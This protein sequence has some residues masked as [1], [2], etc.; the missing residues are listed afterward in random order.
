MRKGRMRQ[1]TLADCLRRDHEPRPATRSGHVGKRHADWFPAVD[2]VEDSARYVLTVDLPGVRPDAIDITA[3]DGSLTISGNRARDTRTGALGI[4]RN[5]R[6]AGRFVR[7]IALP[8]T[9]AVDGITAT[10]RHGALEVSI[11][12]L[13]E[14]QPRHIRVEAA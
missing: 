9:V 1:Q 12:K 6:R 7:R 2:I 13:P 8:E 5:E 10:S 11:P 3:E 4:R 14:A